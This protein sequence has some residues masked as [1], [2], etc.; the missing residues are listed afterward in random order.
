MRTWITVVG[1]SPYAA[2]NSL[3]AALRGGVF[4]PERV[5]LLWDG[6]AALEKHLHSI[7]RWVGLLAKHFGVKIE[8]VDKSFGH[9]SLKNFA[10]VVEQVMEEERH[11][12]IALDMTPG[13]KFMSALMFH[14][15]TTHR[16]QVAHLFYLY[17][18]EQRYENTP[19]ML[20][21]SPAHELIDIAAQN[22]VSLDA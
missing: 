18:T 14:A 11:N 20:I 1:Q 5:I 22:V 7:K 2:I 8:I 21:P 13:R 3:W 19:F 9:E 17:L 16:D 10:Q 4:I 12:R 15:L 6:S